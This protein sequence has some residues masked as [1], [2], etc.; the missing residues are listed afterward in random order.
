MESPRARLAIGNHAGD[1]LPQ[2]RKAAMFTLRYTANA[3]LV[4]RPHAPTVP[5][6]D[7]YEEAEAHLNEQENADVLEVVE[8]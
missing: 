2:K 3:P 4:P 1:G 7:T 8:R 6:F 5:M